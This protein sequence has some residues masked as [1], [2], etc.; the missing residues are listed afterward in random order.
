MDFYTI[1]S[2]FYDE[3]FPQSEDSVD[4][5]SQRVNSGAT[6]LDAGCGTG[7]FVRKLRHRGIQ[8]RGFDLDESMIHEAERRLLKDPGPSMM[9]KTGV[10]QAGNLVDM[11]QLYP[12][13]SF[14]CISCLG[15]TLIHIPFN[16]QFQF[17]QD[18]GKKLNKSGTLVLQI[19]NYINI[20]DGGMAFPLIETEHCL[21]RRRYESGPTEGMLYFMTELEVKETGQVFENSIIHYPLMPETL[22]A[23][24]SMSGFAEWNTYGSYKGAGAGA[25]QLPLI[26]AAGVS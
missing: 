7:E 11:E 6:L 20:L 9:E 16:L 1:L 18:A 26:V 24:L 5:V 14:D 25:D 13:Q 21:F 10:F 2:E 15:N 19:L 12:Q 17:L 23:A 4:F 8:A 3:I 22:M